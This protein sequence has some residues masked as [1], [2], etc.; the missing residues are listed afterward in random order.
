MC[1]I[2]ICQNQIQNKEPLLIVSSNQIYKH[3]DDGRTVEAET[4]DTFCALVC[5]LISGLYQPKRSLLWPESLKNSGSVR[6]KSVRL[7]LTNSSA[8]EQRSG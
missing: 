5:A 3:I 4:C 7:G 6:A 8:L 1:I 2:F